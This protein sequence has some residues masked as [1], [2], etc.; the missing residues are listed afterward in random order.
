MNLQRGNLAQ[1][2]QS[3]KTGSGTK[4]AL[5]AAEFVLAGALLRF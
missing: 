5:R 2:M 1:A 3:L 4:L